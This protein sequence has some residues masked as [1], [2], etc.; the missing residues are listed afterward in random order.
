MRFFFKKQISENIYVISPCVLRLF[1]DGEA[2][3]DDGGA[4]HA[5]ADDDMRNE[6]SNIR[7][8]K[9]GAQTAWPREKPKCLRYFP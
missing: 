9:L 1:D 3:H 4:D 7:D 8:P 5:A 2:D 6:T